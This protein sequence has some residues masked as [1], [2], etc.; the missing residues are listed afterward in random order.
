MHPN[1]NPDQRVLH[2]INPP[3]AKATIATPARKVTKCNRERG[4]VKE[5]CKTPLFRCELFHTLPN[6]SGGLDP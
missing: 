4:R 1:Q 5:V 6:F 2:I 3:R